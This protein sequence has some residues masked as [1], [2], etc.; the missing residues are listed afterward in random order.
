MNLPSYDKFIDTVRKGGKAFIDSTLIEKKCDRDD[1][2]C[3]YVP[4]TALASDNDLSGM[5]NIILFGKLLKETGFTTMDIC[6]KAIEKCVPPT[7]AHLVAANIKAIEIGM[8][9]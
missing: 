2:E 1:I 3:F 5:A 8:S 7:K 6:K 9:L 4:A